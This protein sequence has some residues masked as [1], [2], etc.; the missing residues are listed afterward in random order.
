ML[1]QSADLALTYLCFNTRT[2]NY[3]RLRMEISITENPIHKN[4]AQWHSQ[5]LGRHTFSETRAR[6]LRFGNYLYLV[7]PVYLHQPG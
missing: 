3:Y 4:T 5:F 1:K 6:K 2:L 7:E